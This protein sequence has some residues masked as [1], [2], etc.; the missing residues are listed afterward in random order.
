MFRG[1][2]VGATV[3]R[4]R[5]MLVTRFPGLSGHTALVSC[6]FLSFAL[7]TASIADRLEGTP[8]VLWFMWTA[9]LC[10]R[11]SLKVGYAL[12]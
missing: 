6:T 12:L 10:F 4:S 8:V 7:W 11:S 5:E 1:S 3:M 2:P 9:A